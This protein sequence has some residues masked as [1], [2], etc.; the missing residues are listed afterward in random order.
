MMCADG[1]RGGTSV[2]VQQAI[3][4]YNH[5]GWYVTEVLAWAVRYASPVPTGAAAA[6]IAFASA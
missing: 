5:A 3:F 1:A 6:A 2:G 4:A